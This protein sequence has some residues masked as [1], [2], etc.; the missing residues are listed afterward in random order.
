VSITALSVHR[1]TS[2]A[3]ANTPATTRGREEEEDSEAPEYL[4]CAVCLDAPPAHVYQYRYGH[5]LCSGCLA[6]LRSRALGQHPKSPTCRTELPDEPNRCLAAEQTIARL[7]ATCRYCKKKTTRG[8]LES[9]ESSCPS[10][11]DATCSVHAEGCEWVGKESRRAAHAAGCAIVRLCARFDVEREATS[12]ATARMVEATTSALRLAAAHDNLAPLAGLL[13][14]G[15]AE[16]DAPRPGDGFTPLCIAS[17]HGNVVMVE[18]LIAPG[19]RVN[20]ACT[21]GYTP[22]FV[23]AEH[24]GLDVLKLLIARGADVNLACDYGFTLLHAAAEN[25]HAGVVSA[26]LETAGV[27]LNAAISDGEFAGDTPLY[28]AALK[29]RLDMLKLLIAAGAN[30]N[31]ARVNGYTPLHVA[32]QHGHAGVVSVLLETADMKINA[33]L[34]DDR[35]ADV[36]PSFLAANENQLDVLKLLVAAGADVNMVRVSDGCNPKFIAARKGHVGV[37]SVLIET[38]GVDL[39]A[40]IT[41]GACAD[42]TP[43]FIAAQKN[44]LDV[45]KMLIAAEADVNIARDVS[46]CT[47]LFIAAQKGHAG[48]VDL[49][50]AAGANVNATRGTN[51]TTALKIALAKGHAEVAQKLRAAGAT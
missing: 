24:N 10:G 2:A 29:N 42:D 39:N 7:P 38:P 34:T 11:P 37:V 19:S 32:A 46:G 45:L 13:I 51:G 41:D 14:A 18:R 47:P 4:Q 22:L 44:R 21:D 17:E 5:L 50:I 27:E 33:A 12:Q 6:E 9:H 8:A 26:L 36:A 30:V 43:L 1:R 23:A 40:A 20:N 16:V 15:G 35:Y 25:G 3:A 48:V 31:K 49:L 28:Y